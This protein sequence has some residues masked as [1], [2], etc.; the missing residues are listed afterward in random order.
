MSFYRDCSSGRESALGSWKMERTHV[1]CYGVFKASP[2][3]A[4]I[5]T[6]LVVAM[7][8][9]VADC[10][11]SKKAGRRQF[12][13]RMEGARAEVYKRIG[14]TNLVVH[15]FE[16]STG[17]ATNRAAIVCFFGGGWTSGSPGQF[18]QQCR[19]FASR[20]IVAMAAD[21]FTAE[22]FAAA[23]KKAGNRCEL[24]GYEGQGH[25]FFNFGRG[26]DQYFRETLAAADQFLISLGYL[27]PQKTTPAKP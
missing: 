25:G 23:M 8:G 14:E 5:A 10:A 11:E 4:L 27:T 17:A 24:V 7:M 16:P 21:Y 20:G 1:R 26:D 9:T 3:R 6:C 19:H 2:V 12:T 18:E 15:I 13:E 22:A